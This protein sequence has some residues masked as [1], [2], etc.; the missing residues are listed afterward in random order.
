M[1]GFDAILVDYL[2]RGPYAMISAL[3]SLQSAVCGSELHV[4]RYGDVESGCRAV[5]R[6]ITVQP[7]CQEV[8]KK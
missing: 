8:A 5:G 2:R 6:D 1:A 3:C 7:F 4:F